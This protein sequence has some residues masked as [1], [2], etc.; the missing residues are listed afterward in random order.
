VRIIS[1]IKEISQFL[2]VSQSTVSIVLNG[3]GEKYRISAKTIKRIQEAA[4][5]MG[6][7]PNISARRL[8]TSGEKVAPII[9]LFWTVDARSQL[10]ARYLKGIQAALGHFNGKYEIL[11]QPY[12]GSELSQVKSLISGTR[13]NGAI[14]ANATLED[15]KFLEEAIVNVP[16]VLYMRDS[17]KYCHVHVDDYRTG[18][19]MAKLFASRGHKDVGITIPSV[20]SRAIQLRVSGFIDGCMES[21]LNLKDEHTTYG[22]YSEQGGYSAI[23]QLGSLQ[24][25]PT[26]L[27]FLSDQMAI[28]GL[29]AFQQLGI[30]IPDDIEVTG[31]DDEEVSKFSIPSLTTMHLPVEEMAFACM[32]LIDDLISHKS[33]PPISRKFE[34][35]LVVRQSCGGDTEGTRN[36]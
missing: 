8:R 21:G 3:K 16:I 30:R 25:K 32:E 36:A 9:A 33:S 7:Q 6:Y 26:A 12:I 22:E 24:E 35:H 13:F 31:H 34:S 19:D 27:F 29:H 2:N 10:I 1:S 15:E 17:S 5:S 14:I 23:M 4:H 20:S 18:K 11:I 28:G